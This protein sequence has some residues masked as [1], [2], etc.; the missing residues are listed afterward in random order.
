MFW[1]IFVPAALIFFGVFSAPPS[2]GAGEKALQ[3][4]QKQYLSGNH[5]ITICPTAIKLK[6]TTQKYE[7]ICKAPKWDVDSFRHDDKV[8]CHLTLQEF[9]KQHEYRAKAL[10]EEMHPVGAQTLGVLNPTVYKSHKQEI[11]IAKTALVPAPVQDLI[12]AYYKCNHVDGLLIKFMTIIGPGEKQ[13]GQPARPGVNKYLVMVETSSC[14]E[15]PFKKSDFD[16]PTGYKK[17]TSTQELMT[18][19]RSRKEA[20]DIFRDMGLGE[21]FGNSKSK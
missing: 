17:V 14:A 9:F 6:N 7:V 4:Q 5:T 13:A 10:P 16:V 3:L 12:S 18:S 19:S 15:I 11:W 8:I 1:K 21:D 20:A 2:H